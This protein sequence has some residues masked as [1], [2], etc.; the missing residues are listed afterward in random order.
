[1][2]QLLR[3]RHTA[4]F[5]RMIGLL[6]QDRWHTSLYPQRVLLTVTRSFSSSAPAYV[7]KKMPPKKA[8]AAEKKTVL[9]RPSNNLKIGIVGLFTLWCLFAGYLTALQVSRT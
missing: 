1:M 6:L 4:H 3:P 9:G 2:S 7:K 8:A 5:E